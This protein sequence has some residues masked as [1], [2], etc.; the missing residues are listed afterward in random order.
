MPNDHPRPFLP[1]CP[2]GC[3]S[4]EEQ[5]P[6]KKQAVNPYLPSWE[7]LPDAEPHVFNGRVYI[8]GSHDLFNG[9]NFCLG[10]YVGWSA[11][12]TDLADWRYEGVIF[13]R[14]QDPDGKAH[15]LFCGMAAPDACQGPDGRYYLYYFIGGTG[16]ISVAVCDTPAGQYEYYGHV[17]YADRVPIGKKGEPIQFDPAVFI[18]EDGRIYLYSGFGLASNPLLL[19]GG[20]PSKHGPMCY[21]LAPDM[22]TVRRGPVYIGVK[23]EA[24]S[25]GTPYAGHAFLEASSLRKYDGVYYFVY[26]SLRSH[27][28]CY[29]TSARPDGGF[30]YGGVLVSN[31]DIGLAAPDVKHALNYTGNTHGGLLRLNGQYYIFYHRQTNRKQ[32]SRQACAERLRFEN[33][34]FLQAEITSCGLNGGPLAGR[35]EYEA[36][37]ACNLFSSQGARFYWAFKGP[38]GAHPYFTQSDVDREHSPGQYIANFCNGATAGFKYFALQKPQTVG[39]TLRGRA[40]GRML[41]RTALDGAPVARIPVECGGSP[42]RFAAHL[43]PL[44]GTHAL[45]FT[46]EGTGR[47]DFI[48]FVLD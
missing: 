35:G 48:S 32:F 43:K 5:S 1:G 10:D 45:Y 29:A 47:P 44:V 18:D 9:L 19:Q 7:Y 31:G 4:G 6:A 39:V 42:T 13:R 25:I 41:V 21:E 11:P 40:K 26:S 14:T 16:M 37:I 24:E 17:Q 22:L 15:T 34:R 3:L 30:A 23:G 2:K 28:L 33:G 12:L 46:Y 27:E 38:K 36:R 20:R 8:Y